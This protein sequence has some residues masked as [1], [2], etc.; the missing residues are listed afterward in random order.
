FSKMGKILISCHFG[1]F[2]IENIH[3]THLKRRLINISSKL[4]KNSGGYPNIWSP[5]GVKTPNFDQKLPQ[6]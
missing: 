1:R 4:I 2:Q 6:I 3:I 5:R